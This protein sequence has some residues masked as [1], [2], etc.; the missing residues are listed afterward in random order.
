MQSL[1]IRRI[2]PGIREGIERDLRLLF[3]RENTWGS[4]KNFFFF[5]RVPGLC[6]LTC[7]V[8]TMRN[9]G[10]GLTPRRVYFSGAKPERLNRGIRRHTDV[11]G[12]FPNRE[13][14]IRLV[15]AVLAEQH[16]DWIQQKRYIA[17]TALE[18]AK[19]LMH[20]PEEHRDDHHQLTA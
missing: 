10:E 18:H 20:H 13:S 4:V 1:V 11:V 3:E 6:D 15:G 19:H 16:D 12:I 17:L 8:E 14:I 7:F 5:D 9:L 2:V